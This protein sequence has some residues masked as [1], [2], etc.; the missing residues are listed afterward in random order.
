MLRKSF[1]ENQTNGVHLH[2]NENQGRHGGAWLE[3]QNEGEPARDY[4]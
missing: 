4:Y 2:G 1:Q 3:R